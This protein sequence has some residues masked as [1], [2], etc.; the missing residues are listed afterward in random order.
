MEMAATDEEGIAFRELSAD[1]IWALFAELGWTCPPCAR[2][3]S[4]KPGEAVVGNLMLKL[5][6]DNPLIDERGKVRVRQ[7][8]TRINMTGMIYPDIPLSAPRLE[9]GGPPSENRP[10]H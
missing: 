2:V 8:E 4:A 10:A 9:L 3:G 7:P 5:G 1:E 6:P